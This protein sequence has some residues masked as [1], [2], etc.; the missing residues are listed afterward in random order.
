MK[1]TILTWKARWRKRFQ[2]ECFFSWSSCAR[3]ILPLEISFCFERVR[4]KGCAV[5]R[6]FAS[7]QY[8]LGS[9]PAGNAMVWVYCWF[10]PLLQEVFGYFGFFSSPQ[11]PVVSKSN[12]IRNDRRRTTNLDVLPPNCYYFIKFFFFHPPNLPFFRPPIP[13]F[14]PLKLKN[15]NFLCRVKQLM[16]F[17]WSKMNLPS[18]LCRLHI[19]LPCRQVCVVFVLYYLFSDECRTSRYRCSTFSS[20]YI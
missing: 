18:G 9:N 13:P 11:E 6:A 1:T 16:R 7:H 5:T 12:S 2:E 19:V 20:R 4:S 17:V 8:G 15:L 3:Q 10:S 14:S